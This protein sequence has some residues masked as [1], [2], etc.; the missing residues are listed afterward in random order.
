VDR[1]TVKQGSPIFETI[2]TETLVEELLWTAPFLF[3]E[4]TGSLVGNWN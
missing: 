4:V 3:A 2:A 1:V